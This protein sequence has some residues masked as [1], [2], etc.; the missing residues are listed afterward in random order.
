[1][2]SSFLQRQPTRLEVSG[3][4]VSAGTGNAVRW[5]L[6]RQERQRHRASGCR[7]LHYWSILAAS[8]EYSLKMACCSLCGADGALSGLRL[9]DRPWKR[10]GQPINSRI[11]AWRRRQN[12]AVGQE[13]EDAIGT[14]HS[15]VEV[16]VA[17]ARPWELRC[18]VAI[19]PVA[20]MLKAASPSVIIL[21]PSASP[22]GGGIR[23]G[24]GS[25]LAKLAIPAVTSAPAQSVVAEWST[26]PTICQRRCTDHD[27]LEQVDGSPGAPKDRQTL[28]RFDF[29]ASRKEISQ[30]LEIVLGWR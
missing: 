5:R 11:G 26:G 13:V 9:P 12:E 15:P 6:T 20:M 19:R 27:V 7:P 14:G 18:E 24:I 28:P 22:A 2:Q 3:L 1:L 4:G 25:A 21:E 10:N 23:V 30:G 17:Q 8:C 29:V 16:S